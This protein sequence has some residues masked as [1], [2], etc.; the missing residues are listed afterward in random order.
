M[1]RSL[2]SRHDDAWHG[3][4]TTVACAGNGYLSNGLYRGIAREAELVLLAVGREGRIRAQDMVRALEWVLAHRA[5]AGIRCQHLARRRG[6]DSYRDSAIDEAAELLVQAGVVVVAAAGNDP[7]RPSMP[8]ANA[9][10]VVTV[11]G[12][13]DKNL[14]HEM[15][16]V[17]YRSQYGM[18][19][20][21]LTKP[22]LCAPGALVAAPILPGTPIFAG[23]ARST[24]PARSPTRS[25]GRSCGATPSWGSTPRAWTTTPCARGWSRRSAS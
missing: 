11:G 14:P 19:V 9:P 3:T 12:L 18:T 21:G 16:F 6:P 8:P 20:D 2:T 5:A 1:E 24:S 7:L 15:T 23:R 10:S 22:E 17:P 13:V 4:M 25:C